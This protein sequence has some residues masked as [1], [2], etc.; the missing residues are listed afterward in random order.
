MAAQ[1]EALHTKAVACN[2]YNT[3]DDPIRWLFEEKQRSI[4]HLISVFNM[5]SIAEHKRR[6]GHV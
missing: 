6:H 1:E 4:T 5:L 3:T 2:V